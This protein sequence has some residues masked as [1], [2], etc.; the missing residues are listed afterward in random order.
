M[1]IHTHIH[2]HTGYYFPQVFSWLRSFQPLIQDSKKTG[3]HYKS[4]AASSNYKQNTRTSTISKVEEPYMYVSCIFVAKA[5]IC[6]TG[7]E[8]SITSRPG[9]TETQLTAATSVQYHLTPNSHKTCS[10]HNI[11]SRNRI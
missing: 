1:T 4:S 10:K 11:N 5:Q 9:M 2:T 3:S 7:C 8:L 6:S